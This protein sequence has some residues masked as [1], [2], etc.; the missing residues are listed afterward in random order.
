[1]PPHQ[2]AGSPERAVSSQRRFH[3]AVVRCLPRLLTVPPV[4]RGPVSILL[5]AP[6]AVAQWV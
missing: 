1:M 2:P 4:A 6:A 3:K 5:L